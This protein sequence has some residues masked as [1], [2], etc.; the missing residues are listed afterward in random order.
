MKTLS[1]LTLLS[2]FV[3]GLARE[4]PAR[5]VRPVQR[6]V[7]LK[8]IGEGVQFKIRREERQALRGETEQARV[9]RIAN[10]VSE[11]IQH[12]AVGGVKPN[13]IFRHSGKT[14]TSC[15]FLFF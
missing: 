13:R 14:P 5:G 12:F 11:A 15:V 10:A 1:I 2:L 6:L 3:S 7:D 9:A 8:H 4:R